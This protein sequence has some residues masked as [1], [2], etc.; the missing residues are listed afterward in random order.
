MFY[1]L[2][3]F[4]SYKRY[5]CAF[6]LR[7]VKDLVVPEALSGLLFAEITN[8]CYWIFFIFAEQGY[9]LG[10]DCY[11]AILLFINVSQ[12]DDFSFLLLF[13]WALVEGTK[14][15]FVELAEVKCIS[16]E[17]IIYCVSFSGCLCHWGVDLNWGYDCFIEQAYINSNGRYVNFRKYIFSN[18][19]VIV[20]SSFWVI[21]SIYFS[22]A[23]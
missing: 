16:R 19:W 5:L 11:L 1:I 12:T 23:N 17:V 7:K 8:E 10:F 18:R 14:F 2:E 13:I 22:L 21:K 9:C 3:Y 15:G 20:S 4:L 6:Y